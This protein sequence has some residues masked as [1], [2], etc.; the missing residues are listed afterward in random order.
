MF[1]IYDLLLYIYVT[2]LILKNIM[3]RLQ[4]IWH[5]IK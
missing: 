5:I 1:L 3:L 2:Y 4:L